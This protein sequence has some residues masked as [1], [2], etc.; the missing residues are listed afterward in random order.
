MSCNINKATLKMQD[1]L[2]SSLARFESLFVRDCA[3]LRSSLQPRA[4]NA[5]I[6]FHLG[7]KIV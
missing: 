2:N 5:C 3:Q 1:S 6:D 4:D 7:P